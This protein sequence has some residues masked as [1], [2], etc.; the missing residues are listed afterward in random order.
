[1]VR[2]PGDVVAAGELVELRPFTTER[3]AQHVAW[4]N[5]PVVAWGIFGRNEP[6]SDA[7][8]T[9]WL[10][11]ERAR[12]D[13]LLFSIHRRDDGRPVGTASLTDIGTPP[14]TATFRILI[15]S[16]ADRGLGLGE[17][18]S[19]LVIRHAFADLGMDRVVLHVFEYN[20]AARRLYARLGFRE[21]ERR[22]RRIHRDGTTWDVI[23]MALD[24]PASDWS[25]YEPRPAS[26]VVGDLR[27]LRGL[28]GPWEDLPRDIFVHLP[29]GAE[30]SGRHYPVLYLHDGLNLFDEA[31]SFSGEWRVDE[32]LTALADEGIEVI[33]VGIPNV[34]DPGR[35]AE[36]TPYRARPWAGEAS[37]PGE[38]AYPSGLGSAYL[39]FLV[40]QVKP[41][42]DAAFPTRFDRASTGVLGSSWGGL[43]SLWAAVERGD[44]F[45]LVGAMSPAI[46]PGQGPI[47]RRLR[48]LSPAPQRIYVDMGEHEGSFAP[49]P[50]EDRA[51]SRDAIRAARKVRDALDVSVPMASGRLRYVEEPGGIHQESAWARRLPEALRFLFGDAR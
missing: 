49:T 45:G 32:T 47:Y 4:L 38:P 48:R 42:V 10:D 7:D 24:R 36:Y 43:I 6:R 3:Y 12:P 51:W 46:T 17:D 21:S 8:E 34:G 35:G 5:D 15:G 40:E 9:E 33:A 23:I 44:V 14:G 50:R 22:R 20:L 11:R 25:A 28:R 37:T 1:M 27:V 16:T 39:R 19:R 13:A 30:T 18:A 26:T 29:K 2:A 41:A 31:T